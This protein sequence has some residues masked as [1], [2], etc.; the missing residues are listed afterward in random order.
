MMVILGYFSLSCG[1]E[2]GLLPSGSR[3]LNMNEWLRDQTNTDFRPHRSMFS[4]ADW[5]V[6]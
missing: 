4:K 1:W 6:F 2:I 3:K 5:A